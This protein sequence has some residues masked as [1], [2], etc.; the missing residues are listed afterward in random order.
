[1]RVV[2][3]C[4]RCEGDQ[5]PVEYF[6]CFTQNA[7]YMVGRCIGHWCMFVCM[8]AVHR[9]RRSGGARLRNDKIVSLRCDDDV[10]LAAAFRLDEI[11][12]AGVQ[13]VAATTTVICTTWR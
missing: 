7:W 11:L 5:N 13:S 1:M 6:V 3:G 4:M 10:G 12:R 9:N 2:V 8:F